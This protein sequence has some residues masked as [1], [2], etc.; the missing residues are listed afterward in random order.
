MAVKYPHMK[1]FEGELWERFLKRIPWKAS[2]ISYDVHLGEG[3]TLPLETPDWV[4]R[5]ALALSAKRVDV[6]VETANETIIVE[7]K[8]RASLS[9][10]G[11]LLG[12]LALY[13]K[14]FRPRK[15]MRLVCVCRTV[16]P[17]MD[18]IFAEYGIEV[19]IV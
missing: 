19:Y 10:V 18:V 7:I 15:R 14:Q 9:A 12:Y 6:V 1:Q 3:A 2:A 5:M 13:V 17:D 4:K 11:Q 8:E 16:A